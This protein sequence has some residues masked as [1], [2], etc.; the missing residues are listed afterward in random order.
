MRKRPLAFPPSARSPRPAPPSRP[1]LRASR[2]ASR[3]S[4]RASLCAAGLAF[5]LGSLAAAPA[6][7]RSEK[8]L[9]YSPSAVWGPL[10]RFVRVDENLKIVDRDQEAGY[11]I[12]ELVQDKKTFRGSVEII[13]AT[14]DHGVR[15]I[16]DVADRPSY[17]EVA[18]LERLERKLY[19]ELGPAP[20]PPP[21]KKKPKSDG[22]AEAKPGDKDDDKDKPP[23]VQEAP[24]VPIPEAPVPEK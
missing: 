22:K 1:A 5:A 6:E 24:T 9:G 23:A 19:S 14:K 8:Q 13:A 20:S 4:S 11:L 21:P 17:V 3:P 15:L 7:A 2:P 10:V 12:F 18:M 16:L